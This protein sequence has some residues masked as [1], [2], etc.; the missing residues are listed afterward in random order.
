[1]AG[2]FEQ[3]FWRRSSVLPCTKTGDCPYEYDKESERDIEGMPFLRRDKRSCPKYGHIC[4]EFMGDFGLT[5][6]DLNIRAAIH[7]GGLMEYFVKEGKVSMDS[8]EYLTVMEKYKE[9]LKKY[10]RAKYP[11]YY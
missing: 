8:P 6:E 2:F 9:A 5:V 11:K 10:P 3:L 7:C 1:M 4:P